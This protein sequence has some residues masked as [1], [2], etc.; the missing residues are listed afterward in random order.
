MDL[1]QEI[2]KLSF[3]YHVH[4]P[5]NRILDDGLATK[6]MFQMWAANRFYYQQIIPRKDAAIVSKCGDRRV[7]EEWTKHIVAHDANGGIEQWLQLT[8]ALGLERWEVEGF[9]HV[10]PAV[11]FACD[12]YLTFCKEQPWQE[13]IC[14]SMTHVFAKDI[15]AVRTAKWPSAYPWLSK[16]AYAYFEARKQTLPEEIDFSLNFC[17][18]HFTSEAEKTRALDV[19]RFKQDILWAILD[20]LYQNHTQVQCRMPLAAPVQ[21]LGEDGAG[22]TVRILGSAAG[23]GMPQWNR[24]DTSNARARVGALPRRTQCSIAISTDRRRWWLINC[25]PDFGTQWNDLLREHPHAQ[26]QGVVLTDAQLDHIGGLFSLRETLAPVPAYVTPEAFAHMK[27]CGLANLF[28]ACGAVR[29]RVLKYG[30]HISLDFHVT[31]WLLPML[32]RV[33]RYATHLTDSGGEG[34][35]DGGV[36]GMASALLV[37]K[38]GCAR[39]QLVYAPSMVSF[40][41]PLAQQVTKSDAFLFDGSF[42]TSTEM[43]RLALGSRRAEDMG[44]APVNET[45]HKFIQLDLHKAAQPLKICTHLN[46]TNPCLDPD[47]HFDGQTYLRHANVVIAS[48]GKEFYLPCTDDVGGAEDSA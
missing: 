35:V 13:G 3:R 42:F 37:K 19:V 43:I 33:P 32:G 34:G 4:H 1:E 47:A 12:A 27:A 10:L 17:V 30:A 31:M 11:R 48:D 20:A 36:A 9:V 25:S 5:F 15:H 22:I 16:D 45:L 6:K 23:G 28:E 40:E 18:K 8:D 14:A 2:R 21:A 46:N 7:R 41:G 44:H 38:D 29:F 26:L 39:T 24:E